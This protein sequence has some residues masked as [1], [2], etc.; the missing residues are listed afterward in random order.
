M[1]DLM[2]V[3]SVDSGPYDPCDSFE[4]TR[5]L[6]TGVA[7]VFSEVKLNWDDCEMDVSSL[8]GILSHSCSPVRLDTLAF[9]FGEDNLERVLERPI[10]IACALRVT[11]KSE[12]I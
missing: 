2:G 1:A 10:S 12:R 11:R 8:V 4:K 3:V 6:P 7:G 5:L 9:L